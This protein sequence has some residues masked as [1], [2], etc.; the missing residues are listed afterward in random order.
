MRSIQVKR[1]ADGLFIRAQKCVLPVPGAP[2]FFR[3]YVQLEGDDIEYELVVS[4][5]CPYLFE[6]RHPDKPRIIACA[7]SGDS[8]GRLQ[9]VEGRFLHWAGCAPVCAHVCAYKKLCIGLMQKA[10]LDIRPELRQILEQ[11]VTIA[12]GQEFL[13]E[14]SEVLK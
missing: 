11:A 14:L 2:S 8:D 9:V 5:Q 12:L 4:Y 3:R 7:A 10:G 13:S 6:L 1:R